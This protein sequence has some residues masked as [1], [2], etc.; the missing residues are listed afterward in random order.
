MPHSCGCLTGS[1][2]RVRGVGNHMH[3]VFQS[4][5]RARTKMQF[6]MGHA[7]CACQW[8]LQNCLAKSL[9]K[10]V[11]SFVSWEVPPCVP[12]SWRLPPRLLCEC[13]TRS[14]NA[15]EQGCNEQGDGL[16][17]LTETGGKFCWFFFNPRLK[18]HQLEEEH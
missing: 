12:G 14:L 3:T 2:R 9:I 10:S 15:A 6:A 4:Q 17:D 13:C 8:W 7:L 18:K 5:E 11:G 16:T 1:P